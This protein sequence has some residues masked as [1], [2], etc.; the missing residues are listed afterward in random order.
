M[1]YI[2]LISFLFLYIQLSA[3]EKT[4]IMHSDSFTIDYPD[5]Q[6]SSFSFYLRF[7]YNGQC[8]DIFSMDDSVYQGTVTS[9]SFEYITKY[10]RQKA[11]KTEKTLHYQTVPIHSNLAK[12]IA[13]GIIASGQMKISSQEISEAWVYSFFDC[14]GFQFTFKQN[15][16]Y[17][18][19]NFHC[20]KWQPD[21]TRFKALVL[22]NF[23]LLQST[24]HLDSIYNNFFDALPGG[25]TY[26]RTGFLFAYK[27]TEAQQIA[28]EKDKPRRDYL[29]SIKD[30]IDSYLNYKIDSLESTMDSTSIDCFESYHLIFG[31]DGKLKEI[32][33]YSADRIKIW[34]GLFWYLDDRKEKRQCK[35]MVR[36]IFE[37][38]DLSHFKLEHQVFRTI[39]FSSKDGWTIRDNT[40]Y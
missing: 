18:I 22:T 37:T 3:Q 14:Q 15:Q 5:I 1:K 35:K 33:T 10:K 39:Y 27:M 19:Q 38:I 16:Q 9:S 30:T 2:A 8:V 20:P 4:P 36:Q 12:Q 21:T 23:K 7:E 29:K 40:I 24:L 32:K 31:T 11:V 26:S 28:W 13:T 34:D 6:N 17:F 25:S